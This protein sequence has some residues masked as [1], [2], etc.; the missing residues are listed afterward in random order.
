MKKY[1]RM[2]K[3]FDK[4]TGLRIYFEM[5]LT[6]F[7]EQPIIWEQTFIRYFYDPIGHR[8]NGRQYSYEKVFF[9]PYTFLLKSEEI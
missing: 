9:Q 2:I 6:E 8:I 1:P 3:R 5:M 7:M 4:Y